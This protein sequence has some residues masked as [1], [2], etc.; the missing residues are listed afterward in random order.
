MENGKWKM[1]IITW[2]KE[3]AILYTNCGVTKNTNA[4]INIA[5]CDIDGVCVM[6]GI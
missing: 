5:R 2:C 1:V 3:C 4:V 6:Y